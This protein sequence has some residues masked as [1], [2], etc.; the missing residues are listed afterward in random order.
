MKMKMRYALLMVSSFI[1]CFA[2]EPVDKKFHSLWQPYES[3]K[4]DI[5]IIKKCYVE[6]K[7]VCTQKEQKEA[8]WALKHIG[9]RGAALFVALTGLYAGYKKWSQPK[10]ARTITDDETA[11]LVRLQRLDIKLRALISENKKFIKDCE[12]YQKKNK[13][14]DLDIQSLISATYKMRQERKEALETTLQKIKKEMVSLQ[15]KSPEIQQYIREL[16]DM[17]T[18]IEKQLK[19]LHTYVIYL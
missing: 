11:F 10:E 18:Q 13:L 2:Q 19:Q 8:Q 7:A 15:L 1:L 3:F 5:R 16:D 14:N 4:Q 17:M 12:N 6:K 9:I